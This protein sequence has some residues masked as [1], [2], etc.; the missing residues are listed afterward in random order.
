MI[1]V[2]GVPA[3][4][5]PSLPDDMRAL[6]S[7]AAVVI[8]SPRLLGTLPPAPAAASPPQQR[9]A[10]PRPLLPGLD[11]LLDEVGTRPAVVLATGDPLDSGIGSTLLS[12]LGRERVRIHPTAGSVTLARARMGWSTRESDVLS[13]VSTPPAAVRALLTPGRRILVLSADEHTPAAVGRELADAG[14]DARLTV[15]G[16]LGAATESRHELSVERVAHATGL[17]RLNIVAVELPHAAPTVGTAAGRPDACYDHDG[18]LTKR[19]IRACAIAALRPA[20]GQLLWDLGAGAGS[21]AIEW[22]LH[23][24]R[25]T[26]IAVERDPA[27]AAR[28]ER[29][30]R[31]AGAVGVRVECSALTAA[32][33]GLPQPDAVFVGGGADSDVIERAWSAL[34]PGGRL[35]VHTVTI[36][37]E[38]AVLGAARR[39]GGTLRRISIERAEPLGRFLAWNPARPVVEWSATRPLQES[40]ATQE[41]PE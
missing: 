19:E 27:R 20:P 40:P 39:Y 32:I 7:G 35:V 16:D 8:G 18:Q 34:R 41:P 3:G 22:A 38:Q 23:H 36:E 2:V 15:L 14:W 4:G 9:I 28:I 24:P 21:V 30:A 5:V 6:V 12:R 13:L 17:P 29:N 10:W 31:A 37:T 26:A 11:A 25:C 33:D 1:E